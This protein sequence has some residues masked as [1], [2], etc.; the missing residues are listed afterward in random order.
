M[1]YLILFQLLDSDLN[2]N[3]FNHDIEEYYVE[4]GFESM[5]QANK[6]INKFKNSGVLNDEMRRIK[7]SQI[8]KIKTLI[9][10]YYS[11]DEEDVSDFFKYKKLSE[12]HLSKYLEGK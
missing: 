3:F 5:N 10:S 9:L 11:C 8:Y 1:K 12:S 4:F 6:F 2:Y 7:F